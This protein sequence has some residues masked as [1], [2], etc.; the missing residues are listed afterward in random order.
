[1]IIVFASQT[2]EMMCNDAKKRQRKHGAERSKRI[3]RRIDDLRAAP[4]LEAMRNL[5]GRCHEHKG[6]RPPVLTLDLDGPYRLYFE[7]A[8]DPVPL[9]EDGGLNW[10]LVTCIRIIEINDP[11]GT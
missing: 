2:V 4:N 7:A 11:H 1:M 6:R 3:Q 9:K 5:P 10:E 8:N